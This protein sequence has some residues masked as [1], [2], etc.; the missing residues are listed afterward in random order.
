ML[1][2]ATLAVTP[3]VTLTGRRWFVPLRRWYGIVFVFDVILDA[4]YCGE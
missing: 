4:G 1:L 3:L 2:F